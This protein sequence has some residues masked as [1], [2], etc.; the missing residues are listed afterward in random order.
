[1]KG[2]LKITLEIAHEGGTEMVAITR[3]VYPVNAKRFLWR[4]SNTLHSSI[5]SAYNLLPDEDFP[6]SEEVTRG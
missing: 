4:I 5:S 6:V 3:E 1:M 2:T